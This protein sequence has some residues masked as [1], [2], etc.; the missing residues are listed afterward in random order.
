MK[1]DAPTEADRLPFGEAD[2]LT[3]GNGSMARPITLGERSSR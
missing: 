2:R 3:E 1:P